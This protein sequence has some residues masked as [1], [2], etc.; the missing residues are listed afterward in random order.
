MTETANGSGLSRVYIERAAEALQIKYGIGHVRT[1]NPLI[2]EIL[3][4]AKRVEPV[5]IAADIVATKMAHAFLVKPEASGDFPLDMGAFFIN[6]RALS[7]GQKPDPDA[8]REEVR[9][10]NAEK[11]ESGSDRGR[12]WMAAVVE[13]EAIVARVVEQVRGILDA[14]EIN[15]VQFAGKYGD[16]TTEAMIRFIR[17]HRQS[18]VIKQRAEAFTLVENLS[19]SDSA[20][21]ALPTSTKLTLALSIVRLC[22]VHDTDLMNS[23]VQGHSAYAFMENMRKK[24]IARFRAGFA[25][26]SI[27][28]QSIFPGLALSP[29]QAAILLDVLFQNTIIE[30]V[31]PR[32]HY[33][34]TK[35]RLVRAIMDGHSFGMSIDQRKPIADACAEGFA[36]ARYRHL[37]EFFGYRVVPFEVK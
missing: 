12:E 21:A 36:P 29:E 27:D 14:A 25:D 28:P 16:G 5:L 15:I 3:A 7:T 1:V 11:F 17:F 24:Q 33:E 2:M 19:G 30:G 20:I 35:K 32:N 6:G 9:T 10:V 18:E 4:T 23:D 34:S 37:M 13:A 22:R 26:R 31:K 8:I